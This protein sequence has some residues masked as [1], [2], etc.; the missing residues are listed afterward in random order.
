MVKVGNS[1]PEMERI[2]ESFSSRDDTKS[3]GLVAAQVTR[4]G[5]VEGEECL[6]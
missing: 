6:G 4:F 3:M 2:Q 5:L 1:K